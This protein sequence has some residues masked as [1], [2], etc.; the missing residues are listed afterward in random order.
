MCKDIIEENKDI[1]K[2]HRQRVYERLEKEGLG[3]FADHEILEILL[4]FTIPRKDVNPLAHKLLEEYGSIS[5]IMDAS[6]NDLIKTRG[7]SKRSAVLLTM[8]PSILR[9]Y[10]LDKIQP[11]ELI[12]TIEKSCKYTKALMIGKFNETCYLICLDSKSKLIS[13]AFIKE[14]TQ[15]ELQISS[16]SVVV[17]ATKHEASSVILAHNHPR[18]NC[19]PTSEDILATKKVALALGVIGIPLLDHI[20]VVGDK[21]FSFKREKIMDDIMMEISIGI[22]LGNTNYS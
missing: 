10:N 17:A 22:E 3:S 9:R 11:R 5:S 1:H 4:F 8:I 16:K 7:I 12:D 15:N 2:D 20:I 18:G 13:S 19:K 6:I 21:T 14:G